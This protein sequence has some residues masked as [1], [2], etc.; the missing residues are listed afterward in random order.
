MNGTLVRFVTFEAFRGTYLVHPLNCNCGAIASINHAT[1]T[2][3]EEKIVQQQQSQKRSRN[4]N[5]VR[6]DIQYNNNFIKTNP[7][8]A[9]T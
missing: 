2:K 3:S 8:P 4:S 7:V 9:K 5:K 1:A 6:R